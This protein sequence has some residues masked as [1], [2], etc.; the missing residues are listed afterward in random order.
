VGQTTIA[1]TYVFPSGDTTVK[2]TATDAA[3]NSS[4]KSFTVTVAGPMVTLSGFPTGP[5]YEE[6]QFRLTATASEPG[7]SSFTFSWTV[8]RVY[9]GVTTV[10]HPT[11]RPGANTVLDFESERLG[12]YTIAVVATDSRG[13]ASLLKSVTF[14]ILPEKEGS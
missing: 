9:N 11:T 4:T 5:L 12:T 13:F 6:A 3:G 1:P 10:T 8:T 7:Y 14:S 2:V